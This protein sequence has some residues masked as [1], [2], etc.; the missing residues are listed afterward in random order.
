VVLRLGITDGVTTQIEDGK[1]KQGDSII[2]AL[3]TQ[4]TS[5]RPA[6]TRPPGFGGPRRF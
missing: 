5:V 3:E 6:M 4:S 1:L 2:V